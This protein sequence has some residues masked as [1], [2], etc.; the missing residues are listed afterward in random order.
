[1]SFDY[2]EFVKLKNQFVKA[3]KEL[4]GKLEEFLRKLANEVW[5]QTI[6][7]T[8]V[9]TGLLHDMW[10]ITFKRSGDTLEA[11]IYNNVEYAS[12]VEDGTRNMKGHHMARI[13]IS[14]INKQVPRQFESMFKEWLESL[15]II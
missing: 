8:P 3:E 6:E 5:A 7:T 4:D 12:Y 10:F 9:D 13:A 15:E 11:E 14:E 1:M 2:S